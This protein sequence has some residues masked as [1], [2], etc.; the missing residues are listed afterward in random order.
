MEKN[1]WDDWSFG[2]EPYYEPHFNIAL[3][4]VQIGE[5]YHAGKLGDQLCFLCDEL[6]VHEDEW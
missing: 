5:K 6:E 3:D 1:V 4:N 2:V